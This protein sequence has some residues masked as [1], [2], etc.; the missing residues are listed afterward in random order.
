MDNSIR[1]R[2]PTTMNAKASNGFALPSGSVRCSGTGLAILWNRLKG[3]WPDSP[4]R[5]RLTWS[6]HLGGARTA[7][8]LGRKK[9]LPSGQH[10]RV[11]I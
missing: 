1:D 7:L 2:M 3:K 5:A 6:P 11:S 10:P 9:P 8:S 4:D